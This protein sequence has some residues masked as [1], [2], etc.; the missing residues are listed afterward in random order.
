L[1]P[2]EGAAQI[3]AFLANHPTFERVP[4]APSEIAGEADWITAAGELRT[5]PFHM[6]RERAAESGMDGF[7]AA[8]LRRTV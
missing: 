4:I 8:R 6:P 3:V 2:E 1:E 7:Y 5:Y